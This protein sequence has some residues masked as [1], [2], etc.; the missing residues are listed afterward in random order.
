[1]REINL[2]TRLKRRWGRW[3]ARKEEDEYYENLWLIQESVLS[4]MA[5]RR[6]LCLN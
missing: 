1:M 4:L 3:T 2:G 5:R 6:K